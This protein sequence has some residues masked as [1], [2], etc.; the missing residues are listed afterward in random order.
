MQLPQSGISSAEDEID[1]RALWKSV[2]TYKWRL[3]MLST[4]MTFIAA[5]FVLQM[6]PVYRAHATLLIEIDRNNL[7]NIEEVVGIDTSKSE[8]INT[9]FEVIKSSSNLERVVKSLGLHKNEAFVGTPGKTGGL[10]ATLSDWFDF[11]PAPIVEPISPE[12]QAQ[13]HLR[14]A[15]DKVAGMLSVQPVGGTHLARLQVESSDARLAQRI[16]DEVGRQFIDMDR[17]ARI[18]KTEEANNWLQQKL[19]ELSVELNSSEMALT[20]FLKA[21]DIVDVEGVKGLISQELLSLSQRIARAEDKQ[22]Q[23]VTLYETIQDS[24]DQPTEVLKNLTDIAKANAIQETNRA[25]LNA[26]SDYLELAEVYGPKHPTLQQ[27]KTELDSLERE[28]NQVV[29]EV[30]RNAERNLNSA[31]QEL[32]VLES[33]LSATREEYQRLATKESEYRRLVRTVETNRSL[34]DTFLVRIKE[35][36]LAGNFGTSV[37]R[38]TE[39]ATLPTSP[40]KPKKAPIIVMAFIGTLGFGI[41][42]VLLLEALN[43]TVRSPEDIEQLLKQRLIAALPSLKLPRNK[44]VSPYQFFAKDTPLFAESV[45][46]MRT[47]LTLSK[48]EKNSKVI[49]VTSSVPNEGKSTVSSNLALALGQ[50]QKILLIDADLRKPSLGKRYNIPPYT[51]GLTDAINQDEE[52]ENCIVRDDTDTLDIMPAGQ[53]SPNPQELLSQDQFAQLLKAMAEKYDRVIIDTPPSMAVS[54]AMIIAEHV[55]AVVYVVQED[56]TRLKPIREGIDSIIDAHGRIAGVVLN[57][58]AAKRGSQYS[59][60]GYGYGDNYSS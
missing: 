16:A 49:M 56:T 44:E 35:T 3:L 19:D 52:A 17:E 30:I 32:N 50:M 41:F 53:I 51:P 58:V 15:I 36:E 54:D 2:T 27:A 18:D 13:L 60:Y 6:T 31:T 14:T 4:L 10:Q 34:Y 8:Y 1:L 40:V 12:E 59:Y 26:R 7:L 21:N 48:R 45:R 28:L 22:N 57:R 38:I 43:D 39:Y 29:Q 25:Y 5:L 55:D 23:A 47:A 11:I 33:Q 9:Q 37:A 24:Q 46:T 42:V 20:E